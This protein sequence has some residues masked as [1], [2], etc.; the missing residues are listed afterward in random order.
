MCPAGSPPDPRVVGDDAP[1]ITGWR[2]WLVEPEGPR[3]PTPLVTPF[4]RVRLPAYPEMKMTATCDLHGDVH[5]AADADCWCGFTT[6]YDLQRLVEWVGRYWQAEMPP[7][8]SDMVA[9]GRVD[10]PG[11]RAPAWEGPGFFRHRWCALRELYVSAALAGERDRI[12][13]FY[14]V[15]VIVG[16]R[17]GL[18]WLEDLAPG[19]DRDTLRVH[20]RGW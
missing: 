20:A 11:R 2:Y 16:R 3:V 17:T 18:E 12:A 7:Y 14:R 13:A 6:A 1:A 4:R 10:A 8:D 5:D 15:P 9:I 19:Y